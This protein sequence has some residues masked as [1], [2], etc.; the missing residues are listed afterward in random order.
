MYGSRSGS[1]G[2]VA[3]Q[4]NPLSGHLPSKEA[5]ALISTHSET[6]INSL[7]PEELVIMSSEDGISH[8]SR[9][10]SA[11]KVKAE[12]NRS[13]FGLSYYLSAGAL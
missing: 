1:P 12:I 11:D 3:V 10:S 5:F 6:L 7:M 2:L 8:A 13:G 4:T 9:S